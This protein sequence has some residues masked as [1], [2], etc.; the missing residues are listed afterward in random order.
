[1]FQDQWI[2][3]LK[4]LIT[5]TRLCIDEGW[6]IC[7]LPIGTDGPF[8]PYFADGFISYFCSADFISGVFI[9]IIIIVIENPYR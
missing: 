8:Y 4:T 6:P 9:V 5:Q 3:K 2:G 7:F 1:M